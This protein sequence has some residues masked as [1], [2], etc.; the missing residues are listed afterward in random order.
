MALAL[1]LERFLSG[2]LLLMSFL[3]LYQDRLE[4]LIDLFA[5]QAL[6]LAL[7]VA[8]QAYLQTAPHLLIAAAL[9][10]VLKS[11]VIPAALRR[12][13][14]R[15]EI[16]NTI[17]TA[18]SIPQSLLLGLF[19]TALALIVTE[20]LTPALLP[21]TREDFA[22]ALAVVLLG[23]LLMTGRRNAIAQVVGFMSLENGVV[24]AASGARG[25]P[26]VIEFS[27]ALAVLISMIV[28]GVFIFRIRERFDTVDVAVLDPHQGER[29]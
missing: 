16:R 6:L 7:A 26:L 20:R 21:L 3:F 2:S 14:E 9:A 25:M 29:T 19:L 13:V 17:E 5:G 8:W 11:L 4:S 1:D 10:L 28:I 24:L 18:L 27:T 22:F 12:I 15:L 23:L